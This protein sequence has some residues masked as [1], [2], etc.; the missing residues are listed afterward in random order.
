LR[1]DQIWL[2]QLTL[3]NNFRD[4]A[5]FDRCITCH[6]G[7]DKSVPGSPTDPGSRRCTG[8][9]HRRSNA[10]IDLNPADGRRRHAPRA[11]LSA[12]GPSVPG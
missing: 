8:S 10:P 5:R 12:S 3:N 11:A 2:P 1:I 6:K 4:V 9:G 7:M